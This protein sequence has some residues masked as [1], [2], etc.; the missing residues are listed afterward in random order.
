[1]SS[2]GQRAGQSQFMKAEQKKRFAQAGCGGDTGLLIPSSC[3]GD[4]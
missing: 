1:M 2:L 3:P 4:D